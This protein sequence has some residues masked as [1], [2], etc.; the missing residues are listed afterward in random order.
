MGNDVRIGRMVVILAC[1][2][3]CTLAIADDSASVTQHR[4]FY[5]A[6]ADG[7]NASTF[8]DTRTSEDPDP[9]SVNLTIPT[10]N[11]QVIRRIC[12]VLVA[13]GIY[14]TLAQCITA[15][16]IIDNPDPVDG[17]IWQLPPT[18]RVYS[19]LDEPPAWCAHFGPE[20][21]LEVLG[22]SAGGTFIEPDALQACY[23]AAYLEIRDA[24][25]RMERIRDRGLPFY[26]L[27]ICNMPTV[28]ECT[29]EVI[30]GCQDMG[31]LMEYSMLDVARGACSGA[32][33]NGWTVNVF[34]PPQSPPPPPTP[35][36]P[37]PDD[38]APGC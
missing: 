4:A 9:I 1:V 32:C 29:A 6:R 28:A 34:C 14:E 36:C 22:S 2:G 23:S 25:D 11:P 35:L 20:W 10:A 21:C 30:E 8:F 13:E 31:S 7:R 37:N 26:S 18:C 38:A 12:Q 27:D 17:L 15:F 33:A 5:D 19:V 24:R 3:I 16:T